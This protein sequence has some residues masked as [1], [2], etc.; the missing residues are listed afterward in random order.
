MSQHVKESV[1]LKQVLLA[2]KALQQSQTK[3]K[4]KASLF[5]E[6][7]NVTVSLTMT[8]VPEKPSPKP[9]QISLKNPLLSSE[10]N[11]RVCLIVKDPESE[12]KK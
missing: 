3:K 10:S 8:Q 12:F 9:C 11:S 5:D 7:P 1:D 4:G 2:I 6:D